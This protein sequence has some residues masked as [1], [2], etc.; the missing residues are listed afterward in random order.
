MK[1]K[2]IEQMLADIDNKY[3]AEALESD[4]HKNSSY[5]KPFIL[6]KKLAAAAIICIIVLGTC[7]SVAATSSDI[8]RNWLLKNFFGNKI[9]K[10]EIPL[11]ENNNIDN[12]NHTGKADL[13]ADNN[14]HLELKNNMGVYGTKES[15]VCQYH[16]DNEIIIDHV[17]SIQDNGLKELRTKTF[18]G[19][20]D[21][22][23][24]SFEYAVINNEILGFNL[25][26]SI[27]GVFHY[28]DNGIV[29]ANLDITDDNTILKGCI[30]MLDMDT[31]SVTKLT[32]DNTIGNMVMSPNGKIILI[33]YRA[34]GFW[35]AFN[36]AARTEKRMKWINGY[37]HNDEILFK[38]D[39]HLLAYGD[40]GTNLIDLNTGK[41]L[42]SYKEYGNCNPEWI[43][44]QKKNNLEIKNIDG[45]T[46][47]TINN[48]QGSPHA[49][50]VKG[51]Y[52][53]LGNLENANDPYYLCNMLEK[54][55]I[56]IDALK[57]MVNT[58]GIYPTTN[59]DK[60]LISD[61]KDAYIIDTC[62]ASAR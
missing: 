14:S 10:V 52:I 2:A 61:G 7:V 6:Y 56:K 59:Q 12:D 45:N 57:G 23:V 25:N 55:Y 62:Q 5:K 21:G 8:F 32:N 19:E 39:Y 9:T 33:N 46:A 42:A 37:A 3:I 17:Y 51:N 27:S 20:Y 38:D 13:P 35:T 41:R 40:N 26:G 4:H 11:E 54:T 18:T 22:T 58:A 28:Y 24:F 36:I 29:Y 49:L 31:G 53:L 34:D 30:A 48:V 15:F 1:N 43:Y 47:I 44:I 60:V 16:T 50:D